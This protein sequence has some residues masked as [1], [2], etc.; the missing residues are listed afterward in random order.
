MADDHAQSI[1]A[2]PGGGQAGPVAE[3]TPGAGWLAQILAPLTRRAETER[4]AGG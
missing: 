1:S 4:E 2:S 3:Q